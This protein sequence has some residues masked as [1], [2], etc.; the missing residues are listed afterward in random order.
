MTVLR[1]ASVVTPTCVLRDG[2]VSLAGHTITGVGR[3]APPP[4]EAVVD[5]DGAWLFPGFIDLHAHGGGGYDYTASPNDLAAG[6]SFHRTHGTTRTL[7]SLVTAPV[8]ALC[9][10]SRWVAT[11]AE[12]GPSPEGH[13]LGA[14]LEG[15]FLARERCGAQH[16]D[17][18]IEPDQWMMARLLDAGRGFVRTVTVA[19][20]LP[21]APRLI[22]YLASEG[23]IAAVGH[24]EASYDEAVVAFARG[25]GL[26]TH[27]F[28]AMRP[29]RHR[30]PGPVLAALD[31]GI[32]CEVINDGVHVH[33]AIVRMMARG[34]MVLVTDAIDAAGHGDGEYRLGGRP[35][36]VV[37]GQAR[38]ADDG[39]LAGSTLTMDEAVRRAV[40]EVGLPV[41]VA[42]VAASGNPARVLGV[43]DRCG[44]IAP[45]LDADLVLLDDE[46]RVIRVMAQGDWVW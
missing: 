1:G 10:Q 35:V 15:P 7:V 46:L 18:L 17:H 12:R 30:E 41:E 27:A 37:N 44:A 4:G 39:S 20:E 36:R 25:A 40:V 33:P 45:G 22:E 31:A 43:A 34:R 19:P 3:G 5:L 9:E 2:W 28:N 23:V 24:T 21:G 16:P 14:H 32:A 29:L 13:V 6:V 8:D 42:S 11:L 26:L 38:L